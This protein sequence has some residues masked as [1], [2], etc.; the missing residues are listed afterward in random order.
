MRN[1]KQNILYPATSITH[2]LEKGPKIIERG[3]GVH[4]YDSTGHQLIDGI[5]G[6]WCVNVGYGR[7]ELAEAMAKGASELGYYHTFGAMS[8]QPQI[9]LAETLI[10][11]TPPSLSKV[12]F[13]SSG[14]DANDTLIKIVWH[15]NNLKNRPNKKKIISRINAYHG[16]NISAA[17]LTGL[18]GFHNAFDL[19]IKNIIHTEC[20]HFYRY[21]DEGESETE[22]STRRAQELEDMI[23]A[24]GPDTVAAF[25]AEPIMGAGGVINPPKGYFKAIQAV[26][27]KYDILM[28]VD[29]VICGYGRLGV[30]FGC[31]LYDIVPDMMATAKGLTSGYFPLSAAFISDEI[32]QVLKFGSEALGG[33]SHGYTYSGHPIGARV[34]NVNLGIIKDEKLIENAAVTGAYLHA[35]L[36]E[37]FSKH[38]HIGEVR[39]HGL[40]A[41]VQLIANKEEK[42]FF[43][44]ALKLPARILDACYEKGL[45][46]R[47]LP[48]VTSVALSPPLIINKAHVDDIIDRLEDGI[49]A[50]ITTLSADDLRGI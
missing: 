31:E 16:T 10:D 47:A 11:M 13:G 35:K 19:P 44:P 23:I 22:F 15:Y 27:K 26:L 48:S 20:P 32:W 17:S 38:K 33:F 49:N 2:L 43:D 37:R 7:E 40:L 5:A 41:A 12:F 25:I 8:N 46:V 21:H 4:V 24:E 29:E 34:A 36:N 50:V 18:K 39:G 3:K 14:S 30:K 9:D 6:L 28:I 45:I 42:K 1:E